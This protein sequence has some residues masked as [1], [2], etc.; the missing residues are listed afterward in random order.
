M[1]KKKTTKMNKTA[2]E[3]NKKDKK[4]NNKLASNIIGKNYKH[5]YIHDLAEIFCSLGAMLLIFVS[6]GDKEEFN[7]SPVAYSQNVWL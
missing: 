4:E 7:F 2:L 5:D 6:K 3:L 1:K